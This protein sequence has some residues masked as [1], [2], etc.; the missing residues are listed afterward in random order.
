MSVVTTQPKTSEAIR[1]SVRSSLADRGEA[2]SLKA[3]TRSIRAGNVITSLGGAGGALQTMAGPRKARSQE[4]EELSSLNNHFASY[5]QNMRSLQQRNS[6]LE[7]QVLKLQATETTA[8]T[9]A[10][11]EKETKDLRKLVD[12]LSE[13]KAKMVLERNKW[14]DQA[15]EYKKKWD[16]EAAW[17]AELNTEVAKLNKDLYAVTLIRVDLQNKLATMQEEIDFMVSV[18]KQELK[19]LQ[20]QL[21]QSLSIVAVEQTQ[22]AGPDVIAELY[23]LRQ[24]YENF[25]RDIQEEA[26]AKYKEKFT[27]IEIERERD[28]K[29]MLAARGEL[30]TS[31]KELSELRGQLNTVMTTTETLQNR[32]GSDS[33]FSSRPVRS[34]HQESMATQVS[35][36]TVVTTSEGA[37]QT[38]SDARM[39]RAS[40]KK[41]LGIL[42]DRFATYIDRVRALNESNATLEVQ[43]QAAQVKAAPVDKAKFEEMLKELRT[44]VDEL[45]KEKAQVEVERNSWQTQAE[46]WQGKCEDQISVRSELK[47]DIEKHKMELEIITAAR[48]GFESRLAVAQEEIEFVRKTHSEEM[49]VLQEELAL[50]V[51]KIESQQPVMTGPDLSDTL[52]EIR[53]QYETIGQANKQDAEAKYKEK[54]AEIALLREKDS[55][56]LAA[57]RTEVAEFQKKLS[58]IRAESEAIRSKNGALEDSLKLTETRMLKE[59]EGYRQSIGKREAQIE[60]MKLEMAQNLTNYQELMNVKLALDIEI[61]AYRK[62]LEGE[63]MRLF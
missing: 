24:I 50:T 63:E 3:R 8:H 33:Q 28:S 20:D 21:N 25:C 2:E 51:T 1:S 10:L 36:K 15:E 43:L 11:F 40:E 41:E 19:Q 47:A 4:K 16:D 42:N 31:R 45:S 49:T 38:L 29:T 37:L 44:K 30:I 9:K 56:A 12:E 26:E 48:A 32:P 59:V 61:A 35:R 18:H 57:A 23:D 60:K 27:E 14:R 5:I 55:E 7:A 39:T 6:A 52:K 54:F 13:D 53:E 17:H 34:S 58:T 46:E 22:E 62:L